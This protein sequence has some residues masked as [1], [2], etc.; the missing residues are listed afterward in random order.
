MA[1]T[2]P[3]ALVGANEGAIMVAPISVCP[4]GGLRHKC[5]MCDLLDKLAAA[6]AELELSAKIIKDLEEQIWDLLLRR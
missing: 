6:E 5:E 1:Q 2:L 4:H 3:T